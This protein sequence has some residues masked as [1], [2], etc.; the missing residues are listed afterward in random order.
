MAVITG[1]SSV[2]LTVEELT[3]TPAGGRCDKRR[4]VGWNYVPVS[5]VVN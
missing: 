5:D 2:A 4:I 3:I 1:P